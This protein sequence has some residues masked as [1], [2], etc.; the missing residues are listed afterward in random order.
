MQFSLFG[1]E[2]ARPALDDLAGVLIGGGQWV[3]VGERVRLSVLVDDGWRQDALLD[4][5]SAR[6]VA[7]ERYEEPALSDAAGRPRLG[8]RTGFDPALTE[9]AALWLRGATIVVPA[10]LRLDPAGLRLWAICAGR[11]DEAGYL[12]RT[13]DQ[14]GPL[15]RAAG[16]QLARLSLAAVSVGGRVGPGWRVSGSRRRQRLAELVGAAPAGSGADWPAL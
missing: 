11:A 15:H 4:E 12:L 9:A 2:A 16:A 5:L 7:S 14:D 1:A 3:R 13:R 6:G 8:V 10:A